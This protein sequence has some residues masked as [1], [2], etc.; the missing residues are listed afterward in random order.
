MI[1]RIG[2]MRVRKMTWKYNAKFAIY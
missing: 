1:L 2:Q